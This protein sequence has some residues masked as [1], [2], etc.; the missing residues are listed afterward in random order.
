M[1][2]YR[3]LP[4]L[5][6]LFF[7]WTRSLLLFSSAS[8]PTAGNGVV[9]ADPDE[10]GQMNGTE[11]GGAKE[12]ACACVCSRCGVDRSTNVERR[13]FAANERRTATH[14]PTNTTTP[15]QPQQPNKTKAAR[16]VQGVRLSEGAGVMITRT[17]GTAALRNL[18]PYLM[19]DELK[20]P[21]HE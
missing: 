4:F 15:L 14:H 18:D 12:A 19:L 6:H 17:V 13:T 11:E 9:G 8:S 20:L 2:L 16:V 21:A 1:F 10:T 3:V 5:L 7:C